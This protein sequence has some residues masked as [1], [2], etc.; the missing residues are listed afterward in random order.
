[1]AKGLPGK[2]FVLTLGGKPF[3]CS[4][5]VSVSITTTVATTVGCREDAQEAGG[6]G[7]VPASSRP[8]GYG[9]TVTPSALYR[10]PETPRQAATLVTIPQLQKQLIA[11]ELL[12]FSLTYT[13]DNGYSAVYSGNVS[14]TDSTLSAPLEGEATGEFTLTGTGALS[15]VETLPTA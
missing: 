8:T 9:W 1:M 7:L 6:S 13:D 2:D 3:G 14:I 5:D 4:R 15:I 11:G 10:F 12:S